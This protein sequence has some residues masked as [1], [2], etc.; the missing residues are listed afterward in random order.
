MKTISKR[1]WLMFFI[2]CLYLLY[3][4]NAQSAVFWEG[5][6]R[7][8]NISICFVGNSQQ[9]NQY[10][11][12][13]VRN[14]ITEFEQVANIKFNYIGVN[15]VCPES[16]PHPNNPANDY[17]AGD[18]RIILPGVS[19]VNPFGFVEGDGCPPDANWKNPDG[20]YNGGNDGWGSWSN[21]PNDLEIRRSCV[22]NLKLGQDSDGNGIPW[23]NHTLH[24]VGHALGLGHEHIRNDVDPTCAAS[25]YGGSLSSGLMTP[26]DRYSVMHYQFLEC[27]ING[28]YGHSGLSVWDRLALHILYPEDN[29]KAE[30]IGNTV[31]RVGENLHLRSAWW[32]RGAIINNVTSN[33][34]WY[35]D[36]ALI[37]SGPELITSLSQVGEYRLEYQY[38]DKLK[39]IRPRSYYF[40]GLVRVLSVDDYNRMVGAINNINLLLS[41][42]SSLGICKYSKDSDGDTIGDICDNCVNVSNTN[43][44][45]TDNDGFGNICDAD[46]N[47]DGAT[48]FVDFSIFRKAFGKTDP[49]NKL[50]ADLNGDDVVNFV[51]FS[52]FRG[53]FGKPPGPSGV[54]P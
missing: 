44:L 10:F 45:D 4:G 5:G 30:F 48:N 31:M 40:S 35:I 17:Y 19:N 43:Q 34:K 26:Y 23:R 22:Y 20:T 13:L 47:N 6:L 11:A 16:T 27:G 42:P 24:E 28:N 39:D 2:P 29:R 25:G 15:G 49:I 12:G 51:D 54:A 50:N 14:Y 38:S 8:K 1:C 3:I 46:L 7:S 32:V 9:N 18:I 52:I 41:D 21:P 37:A 36:G 33:M 53:L